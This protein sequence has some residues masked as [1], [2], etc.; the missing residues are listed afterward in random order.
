MHVRYNLFQSKYSDGNQDA[1]ITGWSAPTGGAT[2]V[3]GNSFL[4]AG[5]IAVKAA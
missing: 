2:N 1:W 5:K 4:E 3:T